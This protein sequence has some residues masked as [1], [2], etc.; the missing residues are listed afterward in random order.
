MSNYI[1]HKVCDE[2]TYAFINFNSATIEVKEWI[3]NFISHFTGH[4]IT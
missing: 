2:I 4:V 3:S 1:Y